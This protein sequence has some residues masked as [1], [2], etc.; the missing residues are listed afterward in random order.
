MDS[1]DFVYAA[2]DR[3][4]CAPFF[5]ERRMKCREP[6]RLHRKSG[7]VEGLEPKSAFLPPFLAAG[8]SFAQKRDLGH[9][10]N[11]LMLSLFSPERSLV[12]AN[13]EPSFRWAFFTI[14]PPLF[15]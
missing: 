9:P 11:I 12:E 5:K 2:L 1:P 14:T 13:K 7:F 15:N 8:S 6:T 3:T 10:L 4:T